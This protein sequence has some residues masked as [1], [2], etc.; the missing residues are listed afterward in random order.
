LSERNLQVSRQVPRRHLLS[1]RTQGHEETTEQKDDR[2][3]FHSLP[4]N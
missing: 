1:V 3:L 4:P 2:K